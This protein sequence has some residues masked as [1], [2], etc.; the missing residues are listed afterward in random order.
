MMMRAVLL[1]LVVHS[2]ACRSGTD[3]V[4]SASATDLAQAPTDLAQAPTDL[5][6]APFSCGVMTCAGNQVCVHPQCAA[7]VQPSDMGSCPDG[8]SPG[9]CPT[10]G[11]RGC[12]GPFEDVYMLSCA[13]VPAGC[14]GRPCE[15]YGNMNGCRCAPGDDRVARCL[16]Y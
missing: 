9:T 16:C 15:C 13:D 4:Q 14:T 11:D 8:F 7:C 5:A 3:P 10:G 6:Q 1:V 12:V 2:A